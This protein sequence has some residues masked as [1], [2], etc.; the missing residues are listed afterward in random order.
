M[1]IFPNQGTTE[2]A[3]GAALALSSQLLAANTDSMRKQ[4]VWTDRQTCLAYNAGSPA[5]QVKTLV[6][7]LAGKG[8][9][10]LQAHNKMPDPPLGSQS[11]GKSSMGVGEGGQQGRHLNPLTLPWHLT[12]LSC[13]LQSQGCGSTGRPC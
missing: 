12:F 8:S 10:L 11:N 1:I 2:V 3:Q 9:Q 5:E 6:E 4:E 13:V 7:L